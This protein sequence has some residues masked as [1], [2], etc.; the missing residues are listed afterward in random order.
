MRL[1]TLLV[2]LLLALAVVG[3]T[4]QLLGTPTATDEVWDDDPFPDPEPIEAAE[5]D[6]APVAEPLPRP[7]V[8]EL[9]EE[10]ARPR[11]AVLP[12]GAPLPPEDPDR[13][14]R[15]DVG[16]HESMLQGDPSG[17]SGDELLQVI[18]ELAYLRFRSKADLETIR[19]LGPDPEWSADQEVPLVEVIEHWRRDGFD[20]ELRGPYL[21]FTRLDE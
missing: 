9:P 19:R 8:V 4:W 12:P 10:V 13:S 20:V 14:A 2:L 18:A 5:P 11:I 6:G 1:P 7:A 17:L 21:V 3:T 16:L 15:V